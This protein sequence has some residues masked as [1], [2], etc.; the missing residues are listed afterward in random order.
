MIKGCR[1]SCF[2]IPLACLSGKFL[3]VNLGR[4]ISRKRSL[5]SF[6]QTGFGAG[7]S[8]LIL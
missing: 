5:Q 1:F 3:L 6:R 2:S 8:I 7:K 4:D